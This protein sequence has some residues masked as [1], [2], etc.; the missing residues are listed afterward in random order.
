[1]RPFPLFGRIVAVW[2]LWYFLFLGVSMFVLYPLSF[3]DW[4]PRDATFS[5]FAWYLLALLCAIPP[6]RRVFRSPRK[7]VGLG[8]G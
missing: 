1:V 7:L 3:E 8:S 5:R 6:A 2:V 4:W